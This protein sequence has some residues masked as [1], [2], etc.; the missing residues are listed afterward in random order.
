MT[1]FVNFPYVSYD[2]PDNVTRAFKNI[3]IRP[4][5]VDELLDTVG[6]FD[7]YDIK[8]GDSPE[9]VAF[10][11]YGDVQLHWVIMLANKILNVYR[12]WPM[13]TEQFNNFLQQRYRTI[14]I[15]DSDH[16]LSAADYQTYIEFEGSPDNSYT[17]YLVD[18]EF[19]VRPHHFEDASGVRYNWDTVMSTSI[20]LPNVVPVSIYEYENK[21]NEAKRN[22]II[23]KS[24][25][26]EQ[27]KSELKELLNE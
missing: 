4:N 22:I 18:S 1:Y 2:F 16:Y 23:P 10:D 19:T 15:N 26:V 11:F 13:T 6:S 8:D 12:D 27:L 7:T 14:T 3:S 21:I 24:Y 17:A 25:L 9:T 20:S 5:I